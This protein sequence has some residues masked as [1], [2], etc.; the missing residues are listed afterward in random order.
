MRSGSDPRVIAVVTLAVLTVAVGIRAISTGE[1]HLVRLDDFERRAGMN[2]G[3]EL[4]WFASG[5]GGDAD[6]Y[7]I[8]GVD[9]GGEGPAKRIFNPSYRYARVGYSWMAW[10]LS[11]G[12]PEYILL[13][14]SL[15]GTLALA[16]TTVM[17]VRLADELGNRA[18]L[19]VLNPAL[20][21]G[22]LQDTAEPLAI[23]LLT[24]AFGS[25]SVLALLGLSIV[26][27][28]YL[29]GVAPL[30]KGFMIALAAAVGFRLYWVAHFGDAVTGGVVNFTA[31][32]LG[33]ISS[34]SLTGVLVVAAG[35]YT[36][37]RGVTDRDLGWIMAGLM[38]CCLSEVV[39][40]T[41]VNAVRAAGLL[42]VLWAFGPG[43]LQ[44][45]RATMRVRRTAESPA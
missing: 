35:I 32:L 24:L 6:I 36:V 16:A 8:L 4:P 1:D 14:L 29:A 39:Y 13:G 34:P 42:P 18:V 21:V 19:L 5:I 44:R 30:G 31:P 23:A 10:L 11:L 43:H 9:P 41:P 26:R 17:A 15:T 7:V 22:F 25:A 45:L 33:V 38:V 3:P 28:S 20:F 27:P 2:V 37:L 40:D 12:R